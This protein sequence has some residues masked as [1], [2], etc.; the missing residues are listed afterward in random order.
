MALSCII[1]D[2]KPPR[3]RHSPLMWHKRTVNGQNCRS[4]YHSC[5]ARRA[6]K[7]K[8]TC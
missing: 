3:F 7:I 1:S 4:I 6:V 2:V 8:G 5:A